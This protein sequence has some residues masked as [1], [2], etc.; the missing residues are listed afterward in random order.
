MRWRCYSLA[1]RSVLRSVAPFPSSSWWR[2]GVA[3]RWVIGEVVVLLTD[4]VEEGEVVLT[5]VVGGHDE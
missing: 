5:A 1:R 2:T 4:R 3:S